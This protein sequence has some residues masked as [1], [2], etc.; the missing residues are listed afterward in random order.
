MR[1][2]MMEPTLPFIIKQRLERM[3]EKAGRAILPGKAA[4]GGKISV[5]RIADNR[6]MAHGAL[7][8]EL[9]ASSG[10]GLQAKQ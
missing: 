3:E 1:F 9:M 7:N 6:E 10:A 8:A 2:E 4:I 5:R